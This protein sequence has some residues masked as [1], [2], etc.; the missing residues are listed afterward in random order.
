MPEF[1]GM[2]LPELLKLKDPTAW[3]DFEKGEISEQDLYKNF[4]RDRRE[5]K[6]SG[7]LQQM[8]GFCS[9]FVILI[10]ALDCYSRRAYFAGYEG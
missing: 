3:P 5:V 9:I 10:Y 2:K 6:G 4:F 7:L 8:A 1:F